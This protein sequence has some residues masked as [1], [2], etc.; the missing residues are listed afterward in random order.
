M[1][2]RI[3]CLENQLAE[4]SEKYIEVLDKF[5]LMENLLVEHDKA[6]EKER[7]EAKERHTQD[8]ENENKKFKVW[9]RFELSRE[10][11][12]KKSLNLQE[13]EINQLTRIAD[14]LEKMVGKDGF[15]LADVNAM[16]KMA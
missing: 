5:S 2:E 15:I 6:A 16:V 4:M 10:G 8:K 13:E 11:R 3:K 14:A 9:E 12:L 1:S 7:E